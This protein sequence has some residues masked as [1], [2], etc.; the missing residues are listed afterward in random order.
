MRLLIRDVAAQIQNN[1]LPHGVYLGM[2]SLCC[3]ILNGA[4]MTP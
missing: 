4:C 2:L 1:S 3:G